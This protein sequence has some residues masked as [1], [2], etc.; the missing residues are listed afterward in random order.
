L[1]LVGE[2]LADTIG[3]TALAPG[4]LRRWPGG[5]AVVVFLGSRIAQGL[6]SGIAVGGLDLA[7]GQLQGG[8]DLLAG[9][10]S[11]RIGSRSR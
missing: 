11:S 1:G 5:V 9:F 10:S 6:D 3:N 2:P 8:A 4:F 7:K